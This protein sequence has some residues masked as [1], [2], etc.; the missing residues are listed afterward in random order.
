VRA[1]AGLFSPEA[2]QNYLG[3]N[4]ARFA[5]EGCRRLLAARQRS[6]TRCR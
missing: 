5:V 2:A 3:G 1:A 4:F 6:S